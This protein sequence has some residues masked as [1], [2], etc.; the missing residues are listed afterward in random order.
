[1]KSREKG[2]LKKSEVYFFVTVSN[3]QKAL[4][5]SDKLRSLFCVDGYHLVR[6]N[7]DSLLIS[8]ILD[9]SFTYV[10]DGKHIT[11]H[12]GDTVILDCCQPHEYY[13]KSSFES[14]WIHVSGQTHLSFLK[15][16]KKRRKPREM[17]RRHSRQKA[18][19]QNFRCHER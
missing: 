11:A 15:K 19:V 5:L 7:Y 9:G 13:T 10:K 14:I 4:F 1:M 17:P 18:F 2:V 12:K 16:F 3:H 8:H 6:K